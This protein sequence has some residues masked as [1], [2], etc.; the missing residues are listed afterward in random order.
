M[1]IFTLFERP[2]THFTSV[3]LWLFY[4][5]AEEANEEKEGLTFVLQENMTD[6]SSLSFSSMINDGIFV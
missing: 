4:S 1:T 5:F 6:V 3:V 2:S